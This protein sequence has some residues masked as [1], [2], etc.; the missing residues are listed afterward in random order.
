MFRDGPLA[1]KSPYIAAPFRS[2]APP[3]DIRGTELQQ[4][5]WRGAQDP[6]RRDL[7]LLEDR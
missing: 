7:H 4:R 3:L 5:V 2:F 6:L 1:R